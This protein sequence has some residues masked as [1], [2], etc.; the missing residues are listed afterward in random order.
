M[1]RGS[2][3]LSILL[4]IIIVVVNCSEKP[5]DYVE[6]VRKGYLED[7]KTTTIGQAFDASFD[8]PRWHAFQTDK[9]VIVVEFNGM[10]NQKMHE[11]ACRLAFAEHFGGELPE[12][13]FKRVMASGKARDVWTPGMPAT[14]QFSISLDRETFQISHLSS[15]AW[16]LLDPSDVL[17]VIY[18]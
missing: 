6:F 5:K 16:R 7:Y 13:E 12:E 11:R 3:A 1:K 17:L 14:V 15:A 8:S 18:H 2:V 4:L 9:G 10:T